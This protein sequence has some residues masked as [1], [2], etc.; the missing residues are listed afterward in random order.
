MSRVF[1][2]ESVHAH[3][4]EQQHVGVR[5]RG[6]LRVVVVALRRERG[7]RRAVRA[8]RRLAA[9]RHRAH[10]APQDVALAAR[11]ARARPRSQRAGRLDVVLT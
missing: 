1:G 11:P 2:R 9:R 4:V 7:R 5:G 6:E 3:E 8:R 10:Q